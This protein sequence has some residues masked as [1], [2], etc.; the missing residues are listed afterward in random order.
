MI[1]EYYGTNNDDVLSGGLGNDWIFGLGGNDDLWGSAGDDYLNGGDGDDI[2]HGG[3]GDNYLYGGAGNDLLILFGQGSNIAV[4]GDGNDEIIMS[5]GVGTQKIYG[6]NGNDYILL[7]NNVE[8]NNYI[9]G[10]NGDDYIF[11]LGDSN[12]TISGGAGNDT[13][14]ILDEGVLRGDLGNDTFVVSSISSVTIIEHEN[15]GIDEVEAERTFALGNHLENLTLLSERR[16]IWHFAS[17]PLGEL[18]FNG[19]GNDLDNVITGNIGA[20]VLVGYAGND[21]LDGNDGNDRLIGG[22]DADHLMG[23]SGDDILIGTDDFNVVGAV[24]KGIGAIDTLTGAA[25]SDQFVLG[26]SGHVFYDDG[27]S[28]GFGSSDYALIT[29]FEKTSDTIQLWGKA[30]NYALGSASI[31]GISGTAVYLKTQSIFSDELIAIVQGSSNLD[32]NASYFEYKI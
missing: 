29:D 1:T 9:S 2:L 4:G 23:G 12:D 24:D 19:Y 18:D 7:D 22:A 26:Q 16:E 15:E 28:N 8:A 17:S 14:F 11:R 20:N 21:I 30:S 5:G 27:N 32:L 31:F 3:N 6:G 13:I 10:G 25:G